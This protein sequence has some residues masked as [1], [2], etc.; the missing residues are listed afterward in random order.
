MA[1]LLWHIMKCNNNN[2]ISKNNRPCICELSAPVNIPTYLRAE[3][4][5]C[6]P[7]IM[8]KSGQIS[9][10]TIIGMQQYVIVE[11]ASDT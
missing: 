11:P 1:F 6:G 4:S 3:N 8:A 2:T 7:Q 10:R 5:T 9:G